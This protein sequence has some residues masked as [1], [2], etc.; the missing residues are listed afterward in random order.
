MQN[1]LFHE[2]G[3][4]KIVS[5][6]HKRGA[7]PVHATCKEPGC[8]Q[9]R[10]LTQGAR[11]CEA[12]ARSRGYITALPPT[13]IKMCIRPGCGN[14][15]TQRKRL[16]SPASEAW[17]DYCTGCRSQSPLSLTQLQNHRVPAR[18]VTTWLALGD[19]ISCDICETT[20]TRQSL[21]SQPIVDHDHGHC[22]GLNSCG[23]CIRGIVCRK[24][25]T[26]L[27]HLESLLAAGLLDRATE[28]LKRVGQNA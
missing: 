3:S 2:H 27:G 10:R 8:T 25:N 19:K 5:R 1:Q 4:P 16:K 7:P 15:I 20:L 23:T 28:Y 6:S 9:P 11:Y 26:N 24:C 14:K 22:P 18:L 13:V 17:D 21:A 12:H